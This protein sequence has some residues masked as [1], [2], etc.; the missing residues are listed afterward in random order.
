MLGHIHFGHHK[1]CHKHQIQ[2]ALHHGKGCGNI[3]QIRHGGVFR[4]MDGSPLGEGCH[5]KGNG[6]RIQPLKFRC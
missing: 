4:K 6:K 5:K 1:F 3:S 2:H